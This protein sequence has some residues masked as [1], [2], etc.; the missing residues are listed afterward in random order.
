M[1]N[2]DFMLKN[3]GFRTKNGRR[4]FQ[5]RSWR[6]HLRQNMPK[7]SRR[8]AGKRSKTVENH[9]SSHPFADLRASPPHWA[10]YPRPESTSNLSDPSSTGMYIH[11]TRNHH[12]HP[13]VSFWWVGRLCALTSSVSLYHS[14]PSMDEKISI[15][16]GFIAPFH[17]KFI[18][19]SAQNRHFQYKIV[20]FDTK[21]TKEAPPRCPLPVITSNLALRPR[22]SRCDVDCQKAYTTLWP[23]AS[24][25]AVDSAKQYTTA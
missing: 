12:I 25:A 5:R 20:I 6:S 3:D 19:L 1:E 10:V 13:K 17:Y 11:H 18:I 15:Q 14:S 4:T 16:S 8:T 2:D 23:A 9:R 24:K 7:I 22:K 21:R